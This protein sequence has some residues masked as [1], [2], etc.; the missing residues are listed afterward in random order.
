MIPFKKKFLLHF[1]ERNQPLF[2]PFT[3]DG[4][5]HK[6]LFLTQCLCVNQKG[7]DKYLLH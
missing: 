7:T 1:E 6:N 5:L 4:S 3:L 2:M